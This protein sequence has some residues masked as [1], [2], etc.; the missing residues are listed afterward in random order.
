MRIIATRA[1]KN[2]LSDWRRPDECMFGSNE[3]S[4]DPNNF[5]YLLVSTGLALVKKIQY[6]VCT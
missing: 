6:V 4:F 5:F 3:C 2:Y 1:R